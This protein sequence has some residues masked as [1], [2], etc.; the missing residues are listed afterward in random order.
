MRARARVQTPAGAS[1]RTRDLDAH[2]AG[3]AVVEGL[4]DVDGGA[5][6][7]PDDHALDRVEAEEAARAG[8]AHLLDQGA[9]QAA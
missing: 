9:E 4:L 7:E 6:R 5:R 8:A 2:A 3:A 1:S